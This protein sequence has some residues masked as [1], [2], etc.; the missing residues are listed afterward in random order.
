MI[1]L[2]PQ[3]KIN[4]YKN[5]F[6]GREDVFAMRWEKADKSASGYTPVCLNEWKHGLCNK[7]QRKKC[8]DCSNQKYTPINDYYFDQHLRGYKAYGIYPLLDGNMSHFLAVDFDKKDWRKDILKFYK[9]CKKYN[10]PIY[11]EKSR[12]G[13]GAHGWIFFADKYPAHKIRNIAV[14]I[15]Q[16][17]KI[18]DLFAKDDSFDRLFP[19]QDV[20]SGKGFGNLIALP[21][22]GQLR[23]NN[24]T[25]FLNAENNLEP[26]NDQW[27]ALRG[28][29]KIP[30]DS[31]DELY[32]KFNSNSEIKS[33]TNK[34]N[35][36]NCLNITVKEQ[37]HINK[38]NLPK[39]LINYLRDNL[40]FVNSEFLIKK[41]MGVSV[42][43]MEKYF[44]LIQTSDNNYIIPRGFL[45]NLIRFLNEN[46]IKFELIDERDKCEEIKF[47][48]NCKLFDYQK[49]AVKNILMSENGILVAPSGS[50]KTIM[51]IDLITKLKQ[52]TLI[53]VHKK[54][55]FNQWVDRV[56]NFLSIPKKE[57][58][59]LCSNKKK[60]GDKITVAMVQTL[61]KIDNVEKVFGKNKFGLILVDECHHMPAK[62]FRNA[63]TKFNPYYLY[64]LTATPTR[65]NN[66]EKLIFI[67]LGDILHTTDNNFRTSGVKSEKYKVKTKVII[68]DTEIEVPF[69]VK[70]DNFQMLSKIIIFDSN[71]NKQIISD[72][73]KEV[74]KNNKCLVLTERKEHVEVLNYYLKGEYETIILT[75]DLTEKQKKEKLKQIELDNFQVLI[76]TGQLIGEGADF[77]N[78]NCLF[79]VYPFAFEGKLIQYIGRIQRGLNTN[80]IIYDY[81]DIKIKYLEKFFK[82]RSNYYKNIAE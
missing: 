34:N 74:D 63:I 33:S 76:A 8:K 80:N 5:L 78:L 36:K 67:Y 18:I 69:K 79:L 37:I 50:G 57:I 31:L 28:I 54:Q 72:I 3:E 40:N 29:K 51:G 16:E 32:N 20:L 75:G 82:K 77:P 49:E 38:I 45:G 43:G 23:K 21:L 12:S 14:N 52:P 55:I 30:L 68:R 59:Q 73:I 2:T 19:N 24:N 47:D 25:V 6:I 64:G 62:M 66:D 22:Q 70:V 58:G 17:A 46:N 53:L 81:R 39:I 11:L 65:K 27:E 35:T 60:I 48:F 7:L 15:L 44:K 1:N 71:R 26:F 9:K 42:Y 61:V 10:M 4:I 56:E 41:R 13:N